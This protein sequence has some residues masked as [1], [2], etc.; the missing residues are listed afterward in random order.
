V[1]QD[2]Y[3]QANALG[4]SQ[5]QALSLLPVHRRPAAELERAGRINRALEA[6][7]TDE[8]LMARGETG[9]GLYAPEFA[10]LM[11]YTKIELEAE[12][13]ASDLPDEPW[14]RQALVNY[15]PHPL[16]GM[17]SQMTAHAAAPRDRG[18][19]YSSTKWSTAAASPSC[20]ERSRRPGRRPPTSSGLTQSC[21]T[22]STWATSGRRSRRRTTSCRPRR[23]PWW[24]SRH[25]GSWTARWRWLL[26]NRRSPMDVAAEAAKLRPGLQELVPSL[27][28]LF[29]ERER[30]AV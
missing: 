15:F 22:S 5:A 17:T 30:E 4:S 12:I 1:L 26:Q 11:A 9:F 20:T 3:Q 25:A 13:I 29:L 28:T 21:A 2:N 7:P 19:G 27:R 8:E 6:L 14:T 24:R 23:R 18:D 10:V 16:H